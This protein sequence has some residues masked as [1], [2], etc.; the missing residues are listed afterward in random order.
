MSVTVLIAPLPED[1]ALQFYRLEIEKKR[2]LLA[3]NEVTLQQ[4]LIEKRTDNLNCSKAP[5][6]K[7]LFFSFDESKW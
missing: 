4:I 3:I 7:L 6:C 5:H 1:T 2:R